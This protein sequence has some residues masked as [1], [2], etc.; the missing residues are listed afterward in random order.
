MLTCI[1]FCGNTQDSNKDLYADDIKKGF[2]TLQMADNTPA[3]ELASNQGGG[4]QE[5]GK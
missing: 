5:E 4:V 2:V 3:L 1:F